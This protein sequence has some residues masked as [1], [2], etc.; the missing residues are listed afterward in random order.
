MGGIVTTTRGKQKER[1][2]RATEELSRAQ[3]IKRQETLPERSDVVKNLISK[4]KSPDEY[5]KYWV[6]EM[7][8]FLIIVGRLKIKFS[9][10]N[11][12]IE[13]EKEEE[14]DDEEEKRFDLDEMLLMHIRM[15]IYTYLRP[16]LLDPSILAGE[17]FYLKH[18]LGHMGFMVDQYESDFLDIKFCEDGET[19]KL[20][21]WRMRM[22]P[23]GIYKEFNNSQFKFRIFRESHRFAHHE[24][25]VRRKSMHL[26]RKAYKS[27]AEENTLE[28]AEALLRERRSRHVAEKYEYHDL[29]WVEIRYDHEFV[30]KKVGLK[31]YTQMMDQ[32]ER[33][34]KYYSEKAHEAAAKAAAFASKKAAIAK[35]A[36]TKAASSGTAAHKVAEGEDNNNSAGPQR[37]FMFYNNDQTVHKGYFSIFV[38]IDHMKDRGFFRLIPVKH[39]EVRRT[40]SHESGKSVRES[41]IRNSTTIGLHSKKSGAW[42]WLNRYFKGDS[43]YK[44]KCLFDVG[45]E[46]EISDTE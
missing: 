17:R 7:T 32:L 45:E 23:A 28:E 39:T 10:K 12:K 34:A 11:P 44:G 26:E 41:V 43:R 15:Y 24:I 36:A 2:R 25:A 38:D 27:K 19:C 4:V 46:E 33:P 3:P 16:A 14:D 8:A 37:S 40:Y 22:S 6:S 31:S 18:T 35:D 21:Y 5:G 20:R 9:K 29:F 30:K 42:V 1:T 13:E